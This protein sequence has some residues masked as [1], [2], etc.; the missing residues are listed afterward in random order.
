VT[1][2]EL[3]AIGPHSA[4]V[5]IFTGMATKDL[6]GVEK[7]RGRLGLQRESSSASFGQTLG[8]FV[9]GGVVGATLA[10]FF[11]PKGSEP[12][13]EMGQRVDEAL[14]EYDKAKAVQP[15]APKVAGPSAGSRVT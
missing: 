15:T 12:H 8:V 3:F 6:D 1:P 5:H 10:L 13:K 4:I 14:A 11:A 9:V 2:A 7:L